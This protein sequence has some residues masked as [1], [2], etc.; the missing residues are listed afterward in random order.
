MKKDYCSI[1]EVKELYQI[2]D[3]F[4]EILEREE[5]ICPKCDTGAQTKLFSPS[6]LEKVRIAKVLMEDMGVNLPGVEVVLH[7]R[8]NLIEMRKQ[9]DGILEDIAKVFEETIKK[10][11]DK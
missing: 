3:E 7:L 11:R 2:G 10:Y 4:L 1:R 5:I 6:D 9:F 8:Q